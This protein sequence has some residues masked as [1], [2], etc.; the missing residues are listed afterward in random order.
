[1]SPN[2]VSHVSSPFTLRG[3]REIPGAP[4]RAGYLGWFFTSLVQR[5]SR[6]LR[7][8]GVPYFSKS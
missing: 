2:A 7:T 1:M 3:R 4:G 8:A 6:A 5:K